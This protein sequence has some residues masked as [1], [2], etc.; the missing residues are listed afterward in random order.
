MTTAASSLYIGCEKEL[1]FGQQPSKYEITIVECGKQF[2]NIHNDRNTINA[3]LCSNVFTIAICSLLS[4]IG[5]GK[6]V[7]VPE[8][9]FFFPSQGSNSPGL[10]PKQSV[11][12]T[13]LWASRASANEYLRNNPF[14][15]AENDTQVH[16]RVRN[17]WWKIVL[18]FEVGEREINPLNDSVTFVL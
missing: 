8:G 16:T 9:D 13:Y 2:D 3:T 10:T 14:T 11:K 18:S 5:I 6:M 7:V 17:L 4:M 12:T 15:K 1:S